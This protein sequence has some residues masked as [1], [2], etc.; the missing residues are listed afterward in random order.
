MP[1]VAS[2]RDVI[3]QQQSDLE[4]KRKLADDLMRSS[5]EHEARGDDVKAKLDRESAERYLRDADGIASTIAGYESDIQRREQKA[6][7]IEQ[8]IAELKSRFDRE[9]KELE[10]EKESVLAGFAQSND[11]FEAAKRAV[12]DRNLNNK[13]QQL[14]K[15]F[16]RDLDKL[17]RERQLVL[18]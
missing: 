8:R 14:E 18:G 16:H 3:T 2:L 15:D 10:S 9:F 6:A 1:S 12:K 7:E 4:S 17:E 13:Q 11:N 5:A